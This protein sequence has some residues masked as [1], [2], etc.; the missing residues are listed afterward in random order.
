M[1]AKGKPV[2]F[3]LAAEFLALLDEEAKKH[4]VSPG[5][6][7]KRIMVEALTG[8]GRE[9]LR[10]DVEKIHRELT[11]LQVSLASATAVLLAK[12]G[13]VSDDEARAW[14]RKNLYGK[15]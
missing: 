14:V 15:S 13:K 4:D 11:E 1:K 9:R 12:A 3:R 7:A 10:E 8:A 2:S 6:A 5:T